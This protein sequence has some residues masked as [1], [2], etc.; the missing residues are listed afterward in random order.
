MNGKKK[1]FGIRKQLPPHTWQAHHAH[2]G[3]A[4]KPF[5]VA[6]ITIG[7]LIILSIFL[8]YG[9]KVVGKAYTVP[10]GHSVEVLTEAGKIN[11]VA[12]ITEPIT[13]NGVYL[14]LF[15]AEVD[16]CQYFNTRSLVVTNRLW[17]DFEEISCADTMVR[18][19]DATLSDFKTGT[20]I[21]LKL[22]LPRVLAAQELELHLDTIDMYDGS[23]RDLF[24]GGD[25]FRLPSLI[26]VPDETV[27]CGSEI[28]TCTPGNNIC[29][30]DGT[31]GTCTGGIT[32]V[33]EICDGL[34][35]DCN[36]QIDNGVC[37]D[38]T[39]CGAFNNRCDPNEECTLEPG[40]QQRDCV[41]LTACTSNSQ[42]QNAAR[43]C[44]NGYCKPDS[45]R[46][47]VADVEDQCPGTTGNF[48]LQEVNATG[49]LT[50][51]TV[52]GT[53]T[54]PFS[55]IATSAGGGG[56]GGGCIPRYSCGGWSYCNATLQQS[57]T[58]L[59]QSQCRK[60]AK[61]EVQGC[62]ACQES[63]I[64]S[65]WSDCRNGV[66]TR[67]C[68]DEHGCGTRKSMPDESR[69][70]SMAPPPP[71]P[72]SYT[73]PPPS[74]YT[75]PSAPIQAQ[76]P[77]VTGIVKLW[78]DYKGYVVGIPL[79]VLVLALFLIAL[80]HHQKSKPAINTAELEKWV[81]EERKMGSSDQRIRD[82]LKG[83]EWNE[84]EIKEALSAK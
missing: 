32:E 47:G 71:P 5:L 23:G 77:Q 45:D 18:F 35:N 58:C 50:T 75:K 55:S 43:A 8:L 66:E 1:S 22:T 79:G 6:V 68:H 27:A 37:E 60:P 52:L 65:G 72:K 3:E 48:T 16:L 64:C 76:Q 56:T 36:G 33:S 29:Q 25:V 46:D 11:I 40:S 84:G 42:C 82:A 10:G 73:T 53:T 31:W 51:Q 78:Q 49:C 24:A 30:A 28:G 2:A 57:R 26:C 44:S 83:T 81:A 12:T 13:V 39:S 74:A 70:C 20:F 14:E 69:S 4:N 38:E 59:D 17:G 41:T 63:W 61:S 54:I 62:A 80:V 7:L 15:I 21:L 67:N 9:S 34:D 19:G